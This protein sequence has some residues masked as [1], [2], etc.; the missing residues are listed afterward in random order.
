VVLTGM[1][2]D[3][4]EGA[5]RLKQRGAE[6]W[7]QDEASST[8]YGMPRAIVEANIADKIYSL[9]DMANAFKKLI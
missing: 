5:I 2:S 9:S 4:K 1:G 8:I 6:V 7:A 3:G